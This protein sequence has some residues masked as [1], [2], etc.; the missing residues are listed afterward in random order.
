MSINHYLTP[1][2]IFF[3]VLMI[4]ACVA[5]WA[6]HRT[7]SSARQPG[8]V[9][10]CGQQVFHL[11]ASLV[12]SYFVASALI[13]RFIGLKL[14]S[15]GFHVDPA[16]PFAVFRNAG[17]FMHKFH[18]QNILVDEGLGILSWIFTA[19]SYLILIGFALT[20]MFF[21]WVTPLTAFY[22]VSSVWFTVGSLVSHIFRK[23]CGCHK[24]KVETKPQVRSV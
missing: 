1:D 24:N 3:Y 21:I 16:D 13:G 10:T 23:S 22:L 19:D 2:M 17:E 12:T 14:S 15:Q 18:P 4:I 20:L 7:I 8:A 6:Q 5:S 11:L 9:V